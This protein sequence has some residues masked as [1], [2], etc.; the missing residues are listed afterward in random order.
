MSARPLNHV[1]SLAELLKH[2]VLILGAAI[3]ILPF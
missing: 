3:V 2:A 1:F